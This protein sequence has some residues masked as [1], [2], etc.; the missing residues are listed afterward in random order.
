MDKRIRAEMDR[1]T[2]K[3]IRQVMREL[4]WEQERHQ[5]GLRKVQER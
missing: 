5:I 1:K 2:A 4:A 3:N